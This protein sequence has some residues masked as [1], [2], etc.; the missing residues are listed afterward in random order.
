[1]NYADKR[2]IARYV[3]D[4]LWKL[5]VLGIMIVMWLY[6]VDGLVREDYMQTIAYASA[7]A[8]VKLNQIKEKL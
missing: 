7:F 1:M 8:L 3:G 5:A 4:L 2:K 6:I